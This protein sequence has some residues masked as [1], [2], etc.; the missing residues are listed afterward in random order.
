MWHPINCAEFLGKIFGINSKET[1]YFVNSANVA[2]A[3]MGQTATIGCQTKTLLFH[4]FSGCGSVDTSLGVV[5]LMHSITY[6]E[7]IKLNYLILT[8]NAV[9]KSW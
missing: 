3:T 9:K 2:Y 5:W 8:F 4:G 7:N 1:L 6:D